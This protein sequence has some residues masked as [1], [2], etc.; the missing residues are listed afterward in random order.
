[1]GLP[2]DTGWNQRHGLVEPL[3][4]LL[5]EQIFEARL[6]REGMPGLLHFGHHQHKVQTR[7]PPE[8]QGDGQI[9]RIMAPGIG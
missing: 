6:R 1:V 8:R 4:G 3:L 7:P 5:G 2:G 9:D